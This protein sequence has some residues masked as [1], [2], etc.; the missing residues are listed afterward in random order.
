MISSG[1]PASGSSGFRSGIRSAHVMTQK[2]QLDESLKFMAS[3]G[4][5]TAIISGIGQSYAASA[6]A[7]SASLAT[8]SVGAGLALGLGIGPAMWLGTQILNSIIMKIFQVC[9]PKKYATYLEYQERLGP[10]VQAK[11]QHKVG[12][13]EYVRISAQIKALKSRPQVSKSWEAYR[14]RIN[15]LFEM[16]EG[17]DVDSEEYECLSNQ[18]QGAG[19]GYEEIGEW[20]AAREALNGLYHE[21]HPYLFEA[22]QFCSWSQEIRRHECLFQ[23]N[24]VD[25]QAYRDGLNVIFEEREKYAPE[26]EEYQTETRLLEDRGCRYK[27]YGDWK[28]AQGELN[29][30][31]T[32][33]ANYSEGLY[34]NISTE[35]K[36]ERYQCNFQ[37]ND[38]LRI[39]YGDVAWIQ[40][41]A[42]GFSFLATCAAAFLI[43]NATVG[44]VAI[45]P[46]VGVIAF[47]LVIN[48]GMPKPSSIYYYLK[49]ITRPNE[50]QLEYPV[51][52]RILCM[53]PKDVLLRRREEERDHDQAVWLAPMRV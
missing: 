24:E 7:A 25:W 18:I 40:G 8:M 34:E 42:L 50:E 13:V 46:F 27:S 36:I 45:L 48:L 1:N 19:C 52:R 29:T 6:P 4:A 38:G 26:S 22:R 3:G 41:A 9:F 21:R 23:D 14:D 10:L 51:Y 44:S 17:L 37:V 28:R 53:I 15:E 35:A 47:A 39:T 5:A 33:R 32:Q 16:R 11:N 31:Y 20:K 49:C 2:K 30:I 12:T 43:I